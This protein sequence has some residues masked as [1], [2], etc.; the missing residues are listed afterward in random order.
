MSMHCRRRTKSIM[1]QNPCVNENS[2]RRRVPPAIN[3]I[4]TNNFSVKC[5]ANI[6]YLK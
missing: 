1:P 2:V 3:Y 4:F 6:F 5:I